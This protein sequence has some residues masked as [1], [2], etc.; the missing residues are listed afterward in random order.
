MDLEEIE[1]KPISI[2]D[3]LKSIKDLS[4]LMIDL[5]YFAYIN[6]NKEVADLVMELEKKVDS[7]VYLLYMKSALFARDVEEAEL[8]AAIIRI[9]SSLNEFAN[10][11]ADVANLAKIGISPHSYIKVAFEK[12]EEI[13]DDVIITLKS[14]LIGKRIRD[15][16]SLGIYIDIIAVRRDG[17]WI[18][19]PSSDM[20]LMAGD[21]LIIR[22]NVEAINKFRRMAFH[23]GT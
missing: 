9:G 14:R 15:L 5:A 19:N 10:A 21:T 11:A 6:E 1:Y 13:V 7:L 4:S 23:E 12:T 8:S 20:V 22:G 18:L 17:K 3:I 16:E 2:K